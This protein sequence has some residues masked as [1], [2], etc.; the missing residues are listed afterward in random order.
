MT[1]ARRFEDLSVWRKA[2]QV[3]LDIYRVTRGFPAEER[4][5]LVAQLRRAAVS[6]AANIAEGFN[7]RTLRDKRNFYNIAQASAEE[8]RYY[9]LLSRDL[10]YLRDYRSIT[11]GLDEVGRM[12]NGLLASLER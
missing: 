9:V 8:T 1:K 2:H 10:D 6:V 4:F 12:L 7:R 3:V 5:G 11:E